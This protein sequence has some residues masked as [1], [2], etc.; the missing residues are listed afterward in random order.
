M[1]SIYLKPEI[2]AQVKIF[3]IKNQNII[4]QKRIRQQLQRMEFSLDKIPGSSG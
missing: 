3:F 4:V 1:V 2:E